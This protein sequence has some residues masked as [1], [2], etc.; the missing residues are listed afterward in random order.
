MFNQPL[1]FDTSSLMDTGWWRR[2]C[3]WSTGTQPRGHEGTRQ[4]WQ[5]SLAGT[6]ASPRGNVPASSASSC[7]FT[8][9]PRA[10][11]KAKRLNDCHVPADAV[12]SASK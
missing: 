12:I 2:R 5:L 11:M 8:S 4:S 3:C 9:S 10:S 7:F 6:E 1:S